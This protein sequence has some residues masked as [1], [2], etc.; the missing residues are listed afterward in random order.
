M[1]PEPIHKNEKFIWVH[2]LMPYVIASGLSYALFE[3][4][5]SW[6]CGAI[7]LGTYVFGAIMTRVATVPQLTELAEKSASLM[8]RRKPKQGAVE[9]KEDE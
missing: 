6:A 8:A 1:K 9:M 3:G 7:A 2:S 5:N 4:K